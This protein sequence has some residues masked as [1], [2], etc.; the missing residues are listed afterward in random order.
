MAA[1][2]AIELEQAARYGLSV[3]KNNGFYK[4]GL[5]FDVEKKLR[6]QGSYQRFQE[7]NGGL[8]PNLTHVARDCNVSP[9]YVK[10]I[11]DEIRNH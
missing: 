5:E 11:E 4:P 10:K 3:N 7:A 2:P 1:I 9:Y 8:R 6:V